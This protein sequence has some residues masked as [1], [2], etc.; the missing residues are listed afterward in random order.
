[1]ILLTGASGFIGKH[2]LLA[3]I[4]EHGKDNILALTSV[5]IEGCI[6]VMH[7]GYQFDNDSLELKRYSDLVDTIIHAGAF[8]PKNA[9]QANNAEKC[10]E[11]IYNTSK[12]LDLKFP[13]LKKFIYLSTLDVY[14]EDDVIS[15]ETALSPSFLYGYSKLY[16]EKLITYWAETNNIV[17]HILRVGHVYGPG[18]EAYQKL[19]PVTMKKLIQGEAIEV[20][21]VGND[22]RSFIYIDDVVVA[23]MNSL[24]LDTQIGPVN[25]VSKVSIS[26]KNIV[27]EIIEVSKLNS[28]IKF[29]P[30]SSPS[31]S[32]VFDNSK[33]R[34]YLLSHETS[35]AEGLSKEWHYLSSLR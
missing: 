16:C 14:G 23:I 19:I 17:S 32:F 30:T 2:L 27:T 25:L 7:N 12:L 1:M 28:E 35:L 18:E 10:N 21:G 8:T 20:W 26:I 9:L 5:P 6:C 3:L 4:K 13:N 24:S 15:E 22:L 11:N 33:M 31:R 29:I 34:E